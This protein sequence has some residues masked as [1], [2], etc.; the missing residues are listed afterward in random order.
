MHCGSSYAVLFAVE[1]FPRPPFG[2]RC[3]GGVVECVIVPREVELF[4]NRESD[5]LHA[6]HP[7]TLKLLLLLPPR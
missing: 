1:K 3:R 5:L 2:E 4:Q 7:Q 6:G